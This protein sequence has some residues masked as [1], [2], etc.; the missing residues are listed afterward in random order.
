MN[1]IEEYYNNSC[2]EW[3]RLER[4]RIEYEITTRVLNEY[5]ESC[6][7]VLDVGG[8][9]GRYSILLAQNGHKVTLVDLAEN[10]IKQA[11]ENAGKAGVKI[12]NLIKGNALK[13]ESYLHNQSFDAVLCMGP[14]YHLL[15]EGERNEVIKQCLNLLRPEGILIV[16]FISAY[17]PIVDCLKFNSHDIKNQKEKLLNFMSDGRNYQET[18]GF[19]DAYFVNPE[20]IE[21]IFSQFRLKT[22]RIMATEGLGALCESSLMQLPEE[23]FQEWIDLLYK[24]SGNK[25]IWGCCEHFIYVAKK[26]G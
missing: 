19:T 4:H 18:G 8:G 2:D 10:H 9:P 7:K 23:D 26:T 1:K 15:E 6:S 20:K 21:D 11:E 3:S 14:M 5:I 13:L 16:S 22:L 25:V 12:E 17:A 24:I